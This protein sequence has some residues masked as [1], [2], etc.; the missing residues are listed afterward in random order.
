MQYGARE[1]PGQ[2]GDYDR[3]A[4]FYGLLEH[5]ILGKNLQACRAAFLEELA[6][7][8]RMLIIG[9]G[10]GRM[11]QAL[12]RRNPRCRVDVLEPSDAMIR[13]ARARLRRGGSD[14][15]S[16]T[17]FLPERWE[18]FEPDS[19]PLYDAVLLPFLMD[20]FEAPA[21]ADLAQRLTRWVRPGGQAL[22]MDFSVA[23]QNCLLQRC[24]YRGAR[25]TTGLEVRR[26][27]DYGMAM[28]RAGWT[29]QECRLFAAGHLNSQRWTL[30]G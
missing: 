5:L 1:L 16:R 6:A 19:D 11:L 15:L 27:A 17:T 29:L 24:L 8:G 7:S 14:F 10:H 3:L 23:R 12:L 26:L 4:P 30:P 20:L 13:L 21:Q 28:S 9:E 25:W 2:G 18:R 22:L